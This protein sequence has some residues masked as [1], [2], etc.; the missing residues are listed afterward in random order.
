[1]IYTVVYDFS[2]N[3]DLLWRSLWFLKPDR[4]RWSGLM[5]FCQKGEYS[6]KS[7]IVFLP[8]IDLN[9]SDKSCIYSTINFVSRHYRKYGVVPILTFDLP[10]LWKA[11]CIVNDEPPES[12]LK[13]GV[14][15][16]LGVFNTEMSFL[17]S[18][19]HIM[20]GSGLKEVLVLIY[21]DNAVSHILSVKAVQRAICGHVL[22]NT[23]LDALLLVKEYKISLEEEAR[24]DQLEC[25]SVDENNANGSTETLE[26]RYEDIDMADNNVNQN[27]EI[28]TLR[29]TLESMISDESSDN[30]FS[31]SDI[32]KCVKEKINSLKSSVS[33]SKNRSTLDSVYGND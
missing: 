27:K 18:I 12:D 17:E 5:Q 2:S 14:V 23:A 25:Q 11:M 9:P 15:F 32:I 31:Q 8:M 26:S 13:L 20:K 16:R 1:M 24:T 7:D 29:S 30:E 28:E 33:Q 21:A 3:V 6:G 4:P 22:V 19:E 10:L